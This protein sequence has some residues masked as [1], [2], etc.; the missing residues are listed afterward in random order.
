M[1]WENFE[2]KTF[3][4][5]NEPN[6]DH[7]LGVVEEMKHLLEELRLTKKENKELIQAAYLH[8]LG[9]S[10]GLVKTGF[11]P[12]DGALFAEEMGFSKEIVSGIMFHSGA[13]EDVARN[14]PDLMGPYLNYR[15]R[16]T[17]MDIFYI[18]LITYCD[19]QRSLNG[20]H[21]SLHQRI[22]EIIENYGIDHNKSLTVL[23][24]KGMFEAVIDRVEKYKIK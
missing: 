19:L 2:L 4:Q 13:Y 17:P 12:L 7:I 8:D 14:F 20:K 6:Y 18:D 9:N 23:S 15:K 11:Y 10:D 5:P 1:Q 22:D 3:F 16:L 24:N 21:V